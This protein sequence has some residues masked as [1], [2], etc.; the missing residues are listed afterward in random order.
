M[1]TL[2]SIKNKYLDADDG[3]VLGVI[4]NKDNVS[5]LGFKMASTDSLVK[6]NMKDG[7]IDAF[8]DQTGIDTGNSTNLTYDATTDYYTGFQ[9][10]TTTHTFSYTGSDQTYT[11][12]A[13]TV[14]GDVKLFGANGAGIGHGDQGEGGFVQAVIPLSS[15]TSYTVVVGKNGADSQGSALAYGGGGY[16]N[17]QSSTQG[18]GCSALL[19]G[20]D[21]FANDAPTRNRALLVAGGGGGSS[22]Y[23][24]GCHGSSQAFGGDVQSNGSAGNGGN[25]GTGGNQSYMFGASGPAGGGGGYNGGAAG[26]T[27]PGGGGSGSN[28]VHGT[29]TSTASNTGRA[30][31][32]DSEEPG[33]DNGYVKIV[34]TQQAALDITMISNG[35]TAQAAPSTIRAVVFEEDIDSITINTDLKLYVSRDGGTNW[36]LV[37]L[38]DEGDYETGKQIW[39]GQADVSSQP[40]GTSVKYKITT[41]N[42]K[43]LR[44]HG[45]SVLWS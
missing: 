12:P 30:S 11:T 3:T 6:F 17:W 27:N 33:H 8:K 43:Q 25:G 16:G 1:A 14:S 24:F 40:S 22:H 38:T 10:T 9:N 19:T 2:K 41:H 21:A 4:D 13:N 42:T 45:V 36:G 35:F 28:F 44:V 34:S 18:A 26:N 15:A 7:I 20:T 39:I 29:A 32:S 23:H 5:L 37:T 31:S